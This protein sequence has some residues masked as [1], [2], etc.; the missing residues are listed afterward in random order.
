MLERL[1][2]PL[3]DEVLGRTGSAAV[4]DALDRAD[5]FVTPLD[6]RREWYRCHRLFRDVLLRRLADDP[7]GRSARARP[8]RRLVPRA[9][10]RRRGGRAPDRRGG[11]GGRR[12]TAALAG[13][14]RSS[15]AA[16]S[17]SHLQLGRAAAGGDGAAGRA[18]VR[19][20]GLGGGPERAVR[21]DGPV[22]GRRRRRDRA[23]TAPPWRAGARCAG[24]RR[25]CARSSA[26]SSAPTSRRRWSAATAPCELESDPAVAGY[27]VARTVLGAMLGFAGRPTRR[28][29]SWTTCGSRG[30]GA[31]LPPLLGLQAAGIL[32]LALV[33]TGGSTGSRRLVAEV[34]PSGPRRP[35]SVGERH[36]ARDRRACGPSRARSPTGT[37]TRA[38][39]VRCCGAPS[40]LARTLRRAARAR[41]G[42]DQLPAPRWSS[43][44][45]TAPAARAALAEARDVVDNEPVAAARR[46]PAGRAASSGPA[47]RRSGRRV[48]AVRWS[49]S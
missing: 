4:L 39:R 32:A 6:P 10:L 30:P 24:P 11:R 38:R 37:A 44:A 15:S 28:C 36:R 34:A 43:T 46:P 48:A 2:G 18:A 5:L 31:G 19:V 40:T 29:R 25:R 12:G 8:G 45:T 27:V 42:A 7:D 21:A 16:S 41:H 20:A 23:T 26:A 17:P 14:L 22:A 35:R 33:E 9:R 49:R 13:A 1:S 3:C 47:G